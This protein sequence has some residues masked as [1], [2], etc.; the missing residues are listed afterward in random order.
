MALVAAGG[1]AGLTLATS[2]I[3]NGIVSCM[4]AAAE[5]RM[6]VDQQKFDHEL[7]MQSAQFSRERE[8]N[9]SQAK[10]KILELG[11]QKIDAFKSIIENA[12]CNGKKGLPALVESMG[13]DNAISLLNTLQS[14]VEKED[15]LRNRL[16]P[17]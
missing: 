6:R 7:N 13:L 17:S 10:M 12:E 2:S 16:M 3:C 14:H 4:N 5:N 8:N 15:T 11:A 9:Q 1:A